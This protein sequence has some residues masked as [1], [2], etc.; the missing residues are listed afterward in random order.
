MPVRTIT[1]VVLL[2]VC[3]GAAPSTSPAS[4][5]ELR[6]FELDLAVEAAGPPPTLRVNAGDEVAITVISPET[7]VVH[8]HGYD[9]S[10]QLTEGEP[11]V[12][13]FTATVPGRFPLELHHLH[14]GSRGGHGSH[15]DGP[16]LY[17]EVLPD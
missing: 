14:D 9:H 13:R 1:R 16:V 12:L 15:G 6:R 10:A 7:I 4:A 11:Q 3:L 8:L 17:L 2:A 5:D